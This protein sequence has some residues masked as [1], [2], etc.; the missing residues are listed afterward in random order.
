MTAAQLTG[1]VWTKSDWQ[2]WIFDPPKLTQVCIQSRA[3]GRAILS[4]SS[5][6]LWSFNKAAEADKSNRGDSVS[7]STDDRGPAIGR[8]C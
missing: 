1:S 4:S 3:P 2:V 6:E 5:L 8:L 7:D